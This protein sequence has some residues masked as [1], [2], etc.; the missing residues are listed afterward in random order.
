MW[1]P[2]GCNMHTYTSYEFQTCLIQRSKL[3]ERWNHILIIVDS[4]MRQLYKA[5][6]SLIDNTIPCFSDEHSSMIKKYPNISTII[7]FQWLPTA[8]QIQHFIRKWH[9]PYRNAPP[10]TIILG[11]ALHYIRGSLKRKVSAVSKK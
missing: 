2:K 5:H 8:D 10:D 6:T 11:F 3:T 7:E 9:V 4:T 1:Q